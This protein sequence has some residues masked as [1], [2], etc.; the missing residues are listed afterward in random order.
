MHPKPSHPFRSR[1]PVLAALLLLL[2]AGALLGQSP[3][4]MVLDNI[5]DTWVNLNPFQVRPMV[6]THDNAHIS[7]VNTWLSTVVHFDAPLQPVDVFRFT[8]ICRNSQDFHTG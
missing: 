1:P 6:L 7:A 3:S 5:E 2:S 4:Y 8:D